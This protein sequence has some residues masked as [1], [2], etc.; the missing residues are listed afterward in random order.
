[1]TIQRMMFPARERTLMITRMVT[2]MTFSVVEICSV[3]SSLGI[4]RRS[5][6]RFLSMISM[7]NVVGLPYSIPFRRC[8]ATNRYTFTLIRDKLN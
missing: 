7:F 6:E 1:M 5:P 2:S 3:P 4:V 8:Q